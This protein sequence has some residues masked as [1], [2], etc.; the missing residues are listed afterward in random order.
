MGLPGRIKR[1]LKQEVE[2]SG[3]GGIR[4]DKLVDTSNRAF[5]STNISSEA[6]LN[7]LSTLR[8]IEILFKPSSM[9][10]LYAF[11]WIDDREQ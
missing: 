10:I 9:R 5:P 11:K 2:R 4:L 3:S 8:E 1:F 7:F 6:I